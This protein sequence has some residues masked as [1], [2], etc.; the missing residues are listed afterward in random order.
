[1][2]NTY[3]RRRRAL[4]VVVFAPNNSEIA[5]FLPSQ[6]IRKDLPDAG[7]CYYLRNLDNS[8]FR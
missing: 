2:I 8:G 7:D 4:V 5:D 1:M 6:S 3:C